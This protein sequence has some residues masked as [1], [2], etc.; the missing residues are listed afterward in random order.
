MK[1]PPPDVTVRAAA[2]YSAAG[3]DKAS[4]TC[5]AHQSTRAGEKIGRRWRTA[6]A[7]GSFLRGLCVI[8]TLTHWL[9]RSSFAPAIGAHGCVYL[10]GISLS[11]L[12]LSRRPT[13]RSNRE[14][15]HCCRCCSS[16]GGTCVVMTGGVGCIVQFG[17]RGAAC[18]RSRRPARPAPYGSRAVRV[19]LCWRAPHGGGWKAAAR[20]WVLL[21]Q[22]RARARGKAGGAP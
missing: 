3:G 11:G 15:L 1:V 6:R 22:R 4:S 20:A 8:H 2:C 5:L 18:R 7:V 16:S 17:R 19:L 9:N 13:P 10:V 21:Q 14:D 12:R